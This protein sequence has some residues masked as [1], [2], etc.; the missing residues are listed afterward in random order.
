MNLA[1][2]AVIIEQYKVVHLVVQ[3]IRKCRVLAGGLQGVDLDE[4]VCGKDL[5]KY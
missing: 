2:E 4:G 1:S 5:E 3:Q